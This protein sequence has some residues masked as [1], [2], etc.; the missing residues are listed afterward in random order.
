MARGSS[1]PFS[2]NCTIFLLMALVSPHL[3][4]NSWLVLGFCR[5]RSLSVSEMLNLVALLLDW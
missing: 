2:L 3:G 5:C 1:L 4:N